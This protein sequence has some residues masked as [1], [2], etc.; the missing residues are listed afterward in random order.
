M[1]A[2]QQAIAQHGHIVTTAKQEATPTQ[3][4]ADNFVTNISSTPIM[5]QAPVTQKT[6]AMTLIKKDIRLSVL[7]LSLI[8]VSFAVIY[9][10]DSQYPFL[11][12]AANWIF[13]TVI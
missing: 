1:Q 6:D 4:K 9:I 10:L 12:K 5:K 8:L 11:L 2:S 3:T 7:L 13:K